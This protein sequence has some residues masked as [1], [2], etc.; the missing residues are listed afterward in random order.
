MYKSI[1]TTIGLQRLAQAEATGSQIH[2]THFAVGDGG[3]YPIDTDVSMTSLV[4]EVFRGQINRIFQDP[5]NEN[6]FTVELIIPV[7]VGGFV[8]RE[9]GIFDNNG[10][11]II[12]GNIP[13]TN[14]PTAA[15]GAYTDTVYR[16]PFMV[17]NAETVELKIDPNIVQATHSWVINTLT[18][19]FLIPGG[20]TGQ[21]LKKTSNADGAFTWSDP[22]SA[23]VFVRSVEEQQLLADGQTN[24]TFTTVTTAG[25]AVYVNGIRV[26]NRAGTEGWTINSETQIILG[27]AYPSGSKILGVQNE[28]LGGFPYPLSRSKNLFDVPDKAEARQNLNVFSKDEALSNT[29]PPG[30]IFYFAGPVI[31]IGYRAMKANGAAVSR[32]AYPD[33]FSVIGTTYGQGDGVST[34]NLP[35]CRGEFIRALDDGRGVDWGRGL[36][37]R[38]S[39]QVQ[40]HKHLSIG[41]AYPAR[42]WPFGS[43]TK[44]DKMGTKGGLDYDNRFFYT[45]DGSDYDDAQPNAL[46]VIGDE[47][48]PRNIAF[49]ACIKY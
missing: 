49:L 23:N 45:N 37:T 41:E 42:I 38:Q 9:I 43:S 30:T 16:I 29:V 33:L 40:R 48:R 15:E 39:Q 24:I 22:G 4:R 20:T 47:T 46:G 25:L 34:F 11:L 35:D 10:N 6:L 7:S 17:S 1:H 19:A 44:L 12:V 2:L 8:M 27:Q 3:G 13:D 31:P 26:P 5:E 21:V 18:P 14:K 28:P 36:G 32:T